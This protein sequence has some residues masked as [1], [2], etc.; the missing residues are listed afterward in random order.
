M[1]VF[2]FSE[3]NSGGSF[4]LN[5]RQYDELFENGFY[6]ADGW[7]EGHGFTDPTKPFSMNDRD[8]VPYG[9]RSNLRVE[10]NSLQEAV[11]KWEGATG[12][13]FFAEGCNCCGAP[14]SAYEV[15]ADGSRSY[16]NYIS[17]DSVTREVIRPW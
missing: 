4:W 15:G 7:D 9:W 16:D 12:E 1:A 8:T 2:E 17:G 3:N 10:A 13:D 6:L 5:T 14:F 11:E